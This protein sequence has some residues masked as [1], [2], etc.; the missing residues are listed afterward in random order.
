MGEPEDVEGECNARL[1]IGDNYGDNHA[2]MR[3]S[4]EPGHEGP[5]QERY[6]SQGSGKV[7]VEW[8]QDAR[9]GE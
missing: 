6:N 9:D 3:C 1:F 5:H 4:L 8:E 7:L 2:T